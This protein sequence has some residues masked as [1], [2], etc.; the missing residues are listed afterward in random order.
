MT[1]SPA[2]AEY[3]ALALTTCEV[4]WLSYLLKDLCIPDSSPAV[5]YTDSKSALC[6]AKNPV[7]H[8]KTKHIQIDFHFT[9]EKLLDGTIKIIHIL[10][11]QNVADIFTKPL[12]LEL[13]AKFS[14][15]MHLI[16]THIHLGGPR[17]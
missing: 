2:E 10:T 7:L 3:R 12:G 9:Q 16:N 13:F 4:Q 17:R 14:S 1:H 8:E 6:N 11:L 5:I 15:K